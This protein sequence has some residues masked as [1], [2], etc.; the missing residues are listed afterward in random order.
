MCPTGRRLLAVIMELRISQPAV[1]QHLRVL[2]EHLGAL[3]T[4]SRRSGMS[5]VHVTRRP[6]GGWPQVAT[7]E[8]P[9]GWMGFELTT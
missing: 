2:R 8:N 3:A 1:S 6:L 5:P 7:S 4:K 9:V